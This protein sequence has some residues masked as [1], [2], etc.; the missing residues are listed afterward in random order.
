[1]EIAVIPNNGVEEVVT[2]TEVTDLEDDEEN[3]EP[4]LEIYQTE[5][6][7]LT[8]PSDCSTNTANLYLNN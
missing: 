8:M 7:S 3:E 1:M 2:V 4:S 5:S 6:I